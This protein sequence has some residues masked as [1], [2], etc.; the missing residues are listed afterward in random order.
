MPSADQSRHGFPRA[1]TSLSRRTAIRGSSSPTSCVRPGSCWTIATRS[2]TAKSTGAPSMAIPAGNGTAPIRR[3][4]TVG[5]MAGTRTIRPQTN[6]CAGRPASLTA[7]RRASEADREARA[8]QA[9]RV[10]TDIL[11]AAQP[12]TD[13]PYLER[14]GVEALGLFV[15]A[16]ATTVELTGERGPYAKDIGGSILIPVRDATGAVTSLQIID[17][18]G[19]KMFLPGGTIAGGRHVIGTLDSAWPIHIAEGYATAAAVHAATGQAVAVAF[20]AHNIGAVA[21]DLRAAYPERT[22]YIDADNDHHLP[23]RQDAQGRPR[24]NVGVDAATKAADAIKAHVLTPPALPGRETAGTDWN[25]VARSNP[26][27]RQAKLATAMAIAA[28]HRMAAEIAQGRH[29]GGRGTKDR[30][31]MARE[32]TQ[33]SPALTR[34][35]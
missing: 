27:G 4:W 21:A 28:R 23:L 30:R 7:S 10:A 35:S 34:D 25:D 14:K 5:R 2:W 24:A 17:P 16:A 20:H 19:S 13:H 33:D 15:A 1:T 32:Q 8:Q 3:L 29:A 6:R 9:A 18:G 31:R 11:A 22:I 26:E 12:A